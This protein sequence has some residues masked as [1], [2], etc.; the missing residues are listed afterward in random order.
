MTSPTYTDVRKA[1]E[2]IAGVAH[3]TP[4]FTSASFDELAGT[5]TYFKMESFQRVGA[6]KFRGAYN[7]LSKLD[8][9]ERERG[10]IAFSSG[11]HAQAVSLAARLLGIK[12]TIVMPYDAPESKL[13]ATREY[14]AEIV[15][16]DRYSEERGDIG[17]DLAEEHGYTMIPPFNHP[18]IIAGQ[19]TAVAELIDEVGPLDAV[20][21]PLGGGGLLSGSALAVRELLPQARIY[22]VEPEAGDDAVQSLKA[23]HIVTI[24]T[25]KTIADGAQTTAIGDVTFPLIRDLV[26]DVVTASDTELIDQVRFFASR[27]NVVVEPTGVLAAAAVASGRLGLQNKRVGVV[28]SGGNVDPSA[29]SGMLA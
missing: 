7:A 8:A 2:R 16:Y 20:V 4:V 24:P 22:G 28:I 5:T 13:A 3:R 26:D 17:A 25:P 12:A 15:H 11:N 1:A 10:V 27:L 29:L 23:G 14:G 18:D 21:T 19:G 9:G 6:F